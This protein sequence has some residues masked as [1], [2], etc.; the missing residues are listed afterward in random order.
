MGN[1]PR[2]DGRVVAFRATLRDYALLMA[3]A[4]TARVTISD[5]LRG[6]VSDRYRG[7]ELTERQREEV[8]GIR[9]RNVERRMAK[10][11]KRQRKAKAEGTVE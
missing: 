6:I 8:D 11:I 3:D 5:V 4:E 9:R 7:R 1:E 10:R 2:Y